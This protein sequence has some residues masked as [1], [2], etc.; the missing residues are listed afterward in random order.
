MDWLLSRNRRIDHWCRDSVYTE[1]LLDRIRS[2]TAQEALVRATE[3][4]ER[5]AESNN[6]P[7]R[8]FLRYGNSNAICYA[9]TSA[10]VTGWVLYN[11]DS[12]IEFLSSLNNEQIGIVWPWIDSDLWTRQFDRVPADTLWIKQQMQDMGW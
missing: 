9:I 1:Y 4:A 7:S 11:C 6:Y 2:E 8:D 12:G 10:R 3:A 5:W